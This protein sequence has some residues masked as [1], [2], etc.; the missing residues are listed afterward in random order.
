VARRPAIVLVG[1]ARFAAS[2]PFAG[3]LESF[4]ATLA[5][6]LRRRGHRVVVVAGAR[7]AGS[8]TGRRCDV[9]DDADDAR[10]DGVAL[11]DAVAD[12]VRTLDVRVV[13]NSSFSPEVLELI[14]SVP[15][16]ET[17]LHTPPVPDMVAALR[18]R[19]TAVL[20][21]PSEVNASAWSGAL[22]RRVDVVANGVDRTVFRPAARREPYL[23]WIGRIVPEKG[24][25]LALD[26]AALL[27]TPV[28]VAG[29]I[30]DRRYFD[31]WIR[32]R[33]SPG[34]R[35]EGHLEPVGLATLLGSATATLVTPLWPEPFG[36]TVIESL[37]CGT[38]VAAVANGALRPGPEASFCTPAVVCADE[39]TPAGLA[40]AVLSASSAPRSRC[41][42][43]SAPFDLGRVV[44]EWERRYGLEV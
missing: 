4:V 19:P 39:A 36:L 28:R 17:T 33:T 30:H 20:S 35:Y 23:A 18:A 13:H 44:A 41:R 42:A 2:P 10:R 26:T 16:F 24:L 37:A 29:P 8:G 9:A 38:P 22:G 14:G 7:R 43:S 6:G 11:R 5:T 3:G 25:H 31:E 27:E 1:P 32:P 15:R 12:V 21:T 40:A 34:V